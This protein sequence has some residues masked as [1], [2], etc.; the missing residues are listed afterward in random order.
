MLAF[1]PD[2]I[3]LILLSKSN[4]TSCIEVGVGSKISLGTL[5][6]WQI[7]NYVMHSIDYFCICLLISPWCLSLYPLCSLKKVERSQLPSHVH[8]IKGE[9]CI[10]RGR[11]FAMCPEYTHLLCLWSC[12][13]WM[14]NEKLVFII[15]AYS[16]PLNIH[17]QLILLKCPTVIPAGRSLGIGW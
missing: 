15:K 13:P 9:K 17:T 2:V 6:W 7:V 11:G 16:S 4:R 8:V 14:R 3:L 12:W 1:K 10:W 5:L